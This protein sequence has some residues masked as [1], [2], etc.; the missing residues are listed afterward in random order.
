[1]I[2][3]IIFRNLKDQKISL[4]F[5][6]IGLIL[7]VSL[8][9]AFYPSVKESAQNITSYFENLP[10]ALRA[11]VGEATDYATPAGYLNSELFTFFMPTLLIIF[12]VAAGSGAIAGE[13]DKGTL[14]LLLA[15]PIPRFQVVVEKFILMILTT[16]ILSSITA[17]S[18]IIGTQSIG[19]DVNPM[20]I[21]D[22]M[23]SVSLLA[24][25]FG[26]ISLA[27]SA[28]TGSRSI[29]I[30][31]SASLAVISFFLYGLSPIV[32]FLKDYQKFSLS[33][34]Y[35][36]NNPLKN[37]L[38]LEHMAVFIAVTLVFLLISIVSFQKRDL[39]I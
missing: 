31:I 5:W 14:D 17:I 18:L 26:S 23:I 8:L 6:S 13:E 4:L 7:T 24:L 36:E 32:N 35:S 11:F 15:N 2:G 30:G 3:N 25:A 12:T 10:E 33:Y 21:V 38:K 16:A 29:G 1:M 9:I 20:R 34:Y 39:K 19:M 27:L 22:V 28:A 37:G